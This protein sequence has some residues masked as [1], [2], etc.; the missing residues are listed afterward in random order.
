MQ[1]LIEQNKVYIYIKRVG[2]RYVYYRTNLH[3][4]YNKDITNYP[5]TITRV[6]HIMDHHKT[7]QL[8]SNCNN[9]EKGHTYQLQ[10]FKM[11]PTPAKVPNGEQGTGG[12]IV[13]GPPGFEF[14]AEIICFKCD[15]EGHLTK[16]CSFASKDKGSDLN[17]KDVILDE[18]YK[19]KL[20]QCNCNK[21][22]ANLLQ[23][24]M[25]TSSSNY[26]DKDIIPLVEEY[27]GIQDNKPDH[28]DIATMFLY[29]TAH[30]IG[31]YQ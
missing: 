28:D 14:K 24:T 26:I 7:L 2:Q 15:R 13:G 21:V 20:A 3:N 11:V 6:H 25:E 27:L 16:E 4:N 8:T 19:Q 17:T 29:S 9:I 22:S 5:T 31:V 23:S 1:L 12:L 18:K 30:L 10:D